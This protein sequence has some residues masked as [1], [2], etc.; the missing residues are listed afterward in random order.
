[1][2]ERAKTSRQKSGGRNTNSE[3]NEDQQ[4][5]VKVARVDRQPRKKRMTFKKALVHVTGAW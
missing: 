3:E 4:E 5:E 2:N 1:M